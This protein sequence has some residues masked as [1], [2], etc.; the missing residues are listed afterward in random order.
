MNA[1]DRVFRIIPKDLMKG[2]VFDKLDTDRVIP[3]FEN[4]SEEEEFWEMDIFEAD[5]MYC[6]D[7]YT[8]CGQ[9]YSA[10]DICIMLNLFAE[11]ARLDLIDL[12][13]VTP[14][15]IVSTTVYYI[16]RFQIMDEFEE[17]CKEKLRVT[18]I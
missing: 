12:E 8:W 16:L 17:W 10:E 2:F 14:L 11:N 9:E 7:F 6:E 18:A 3:N 15:N 13:V 1:L 5:L 4:E